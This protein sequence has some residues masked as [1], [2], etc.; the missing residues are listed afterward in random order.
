MMEFDALYQ[1]LAHGP[2]LFQALLLGITPDEARLRPTLDSWSILEVV[3]HLYD[4]EV[5]DFRPRLD[6]M[7]H[8]PNEAF[9]PNNQQEWVTERR[10]NEQDLGDMLGKFLAERAKSLAWLR[11]LN[12][13]NWEAAYTTPWRTMKAGD[14]LASWVA[15]DLL[16]LRQLVELRYARVLALSAP[17][18]VAYA[19]DW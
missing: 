2:E 9:A 1:E 3:C 17:Y 10:Y 13:A 18:D 16:H 19:G 14:M 5:N 6:I 12:G 4:E 7:L 15:H 11:S 8:R